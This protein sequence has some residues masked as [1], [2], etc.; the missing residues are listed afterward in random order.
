MNKDATYADLLARTDAPAGS[1]W[2]IFGADD[3]IGSVNHLTPECVLEA[4]RSV[5][6]GALF[7]LDYPVNKFNP[8]LSTTRGL[9][10]HTIFQPSHLGRDDYLDNFYL[11]STS[12][13][14]GLRHMRTVDGFYNDWPEE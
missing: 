3:E 6:R 12:Q 13:I 8:P 2:G 9:A 11:Q 7:N 4:A 14:D 5:V 1:C 10:K